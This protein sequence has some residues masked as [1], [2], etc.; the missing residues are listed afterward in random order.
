MEDM[1]IFLN[2]DSPLETKPP[3]RSA[4]PLLEKEGMRPEGTFP[5]PLLE[6]EGMRPEGAFLPPLLEKEGMRPEG[7]F[8]PPLLFKEGSPLVAGVVADSVQTPIGSPG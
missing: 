3:R 4:P 6:Q 2:P 7:V 8:L 1:G 5:P